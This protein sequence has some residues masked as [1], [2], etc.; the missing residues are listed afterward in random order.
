MDDG[1]SCT[2]ST[3]EV[4]PVHEDGVIALNV[5]PVD[6]SPGDQ[7]LNSPFLSLSKEEKT[8]S[9]RF[10][11]EDVPNPLMRGWSTGDSMPMGLPDAP[12]R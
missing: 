11:R 2:H 8:S 9:T 7:F 10:Q 6:G 3:F 4:V 5:A 12:H 1:Q